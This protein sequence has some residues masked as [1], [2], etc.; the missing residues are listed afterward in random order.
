MEAM[1]G[2][3]SVA[4]AAAAAA[5]SESSIADSLPANA[6]AVMVANASGNPNAGAAVISEA[7]NAE[8]QRQWQQYQQ[9]YWT[10]YAAWSQY[11]QQYQQQQQEQAQVAAAV[12][13]GAT[14]EE[15][16]ETVLSL[17]RDRPRD[18]TVYGHSIFEG[19][20]VELVGECTLSFCKTFKLSFYFPLIFR[21]H[22]GA[23]H[24]S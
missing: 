22:L 16:D 2:R 4:A 7:Q 6:L 23:R 12:A 10:Q 19:E 24:G 1:G 13:A 17:G 11:Q 15:S 18:P 21:A 3:A 9:Q 8:Y 14:G 20:E 5:A